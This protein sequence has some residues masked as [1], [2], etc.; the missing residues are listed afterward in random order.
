[1]KRVPPPVFVL[2]VAVL[3]VSPWGNYP[4]NDDWQ[5]A[6]AAKGFAETGQFVVDTGVAPSL[7]GQI[8][9]AQPVIRILGFSHL[10]L[11]VLTFSL[12]IALLL[13]LGE[14]L[15]LA[16]VGQSG[17]RLT[18]LVVLLN[19]LYL[20]L[21]LSFMTEIYAY[22]P[23]FLAAVVWFRSRRSRDFEGDALVSAPSC[24]ASALLA[25]TSFWIR[26]QAV[27][28]FP[29]LAVATLLGAASRGELRRVR[30]SLLALLLGIAVAAAAVLAYFWSSISGD[31]LRPELT[32][33]LHN[34]FRLSAQTWLLQAGIFV[35]YMT[36]FTLPLLLLL[37]WHGCSVRSVAPAGL[38][39]VI[40]AL[41][42]VFVLRHAPSDLDVAA[43]RHR[44]FPFIGNTI[45]NAGVGPV[46]LSDVYILNLPLRPH[47]SPVVWRVVEYV[48][49]PASILWAAALIRLRRVLSGR[50]EGLEAEISAFGVLFGLGSLAL[51][52]QAFRFTLFD[53]YYFPA[54]L[55][56]ALALGILVWPA[57]GRHTG[58]R[59][60][61]FGLAL[62]P[63][64]FF[65]IAGL[66]DLFAW[67][68]ARWDLYEGAVASGIPR[69]TIEAGYEIDGWFLFD[70]YSAE[71]PVTG[72]RGPC[73]CD[74]GWYCRDNSYTVAMNPR[75]GYGIIAE[76][77]PRYWLAQGPPL[78]LLRRL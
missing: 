42:S 15:R 46:T 78:L 4:L 47:W 29:A 56:F 30:A 61:G 63:I 28:V 54:L 25:G 67:N 9:L 23:A 1:M 64:A 43:F 68:N 50:Q 35:F 10:K 34:A 16:G 27:L 26:P 31:Y 3:L 60:V 76:R 58:L 6:R 38:L 39:I 72:C 66:H 75:P 48:L 41:I 44:T 37:S 59:H 11:R 20:F 53:R 12:S 32:T 52:V 51:S 55:G 8:V 2:I 45:Y 33:P 19:P 24:V 73:R 49:L 13:A 5:Y 65:A 40:S 18:L 57:H 17:R 7:I 21:S 22:L 14:L 36:A 74:V 77:Q 70:G 71:S 69:Q 62:A